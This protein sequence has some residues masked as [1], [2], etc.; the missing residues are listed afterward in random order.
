MIPLLLALAQQ[1]ALEAGG[2]L[3]P[4]LATAA[5]YASGNRTGALREIREWGAFEIS[6]ATGSLQAREKSLRSA[7][8]LPDEI[9]FR[10]VE[11]AILL[12]AEAGILYLQEQRPPA[13]KRHFD[14]STKLLRWARAAAARARNRTTV[15]GKVYDDVPREPRWELQESIDVRDF[16]VALSSASLALGFPGV[17]VPFAEKAREEAPRDAEVQL[18]LGCAAEAFAAELALLHRHRDA[19]RARR[20]AETA[21]RGALALAPGTVEAR[22]R[23]GKLLL[24]GSRVADAEPLLAAADAGAKDARQRYLARLFRGRAF[25]RLG[26]SDHAIG[27]YR[28]ALETWPDSQ[29]ARLALAHALEKSSG[30]GASRGLV[31]TVLDPIRRPDAKPDPWFVYPI[32]PPGLATAAFARVFQRKAAP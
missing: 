14:A 4:Y 25:E 30:P 20:D 10:T 28:R 6:R 27:S 11:A 24:D 9:G 5:E 21:L 8:R 7:V 2:D 16:Y 17:A 3:G 13:A 32:G 19:S 26:Q 23:L 12:H 18:V 29:A 1:P 22:L 15:R 31:Q